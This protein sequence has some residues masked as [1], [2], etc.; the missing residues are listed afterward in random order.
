M[1]SRELDNVAIEAKTDTARMWEVKVYYM[2]LIEK[3]AQD[4]WYKMNSEAHFIDDCYRKIEYAV[5][6]FDI[7]KGNFDNR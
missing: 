1:N 4:H 3:L 7:E 6:S 2:P 5:R